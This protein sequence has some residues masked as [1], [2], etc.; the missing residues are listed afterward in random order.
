MNDRVL[1]GPGEVRHAGWK[2]D[3]P[4]RR[5][6]DTLGPV[7]GLADPDPERAGDHGVSI[8]EW[9]IVSVGYG[10]CTSREPHAGEEGARTGDAALDVDLLDAGRV[11]KILPDNGFEGLDDD[12][13]GH[14]L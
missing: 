3:H 11:R 4:A 14:G 10:F 9:G 8:D 7:E 1:V 6:G 2:R 5:H 12:A 13:V